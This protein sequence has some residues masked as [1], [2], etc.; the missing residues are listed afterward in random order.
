[1][2][3][4]KLFNFS[5]NT[6]ISLALLLILANIAF[7]VDTAKVKIIDT[8]GCNL[9]IVEETDTN[10][11]SLKS[12]SG[13][14]NW[15][16]GVFEGLDTSN[17]TTFSLC[18]DGTGTPE[19]PGDVSKWDGL[20]PVYTYGKYW[21]YN[22][23]I[24]YTKNADGYWVSSDIFA[25]EKLA[26]NGKT[27]EQTVIPTELSEEFLS[28]DGNYWSAWQE[29]QDT[30][31]NVGSNIF[32]LTKQFNSPNTSLAMRIPYTYDYEYE[33]MKKL[34]QANVSGVT[35]H[36]I[37]KSIRNHNLYVV[38]VSDSTASEEELKDRRVVLMYANEDGDEPDGC[39]VVN[40]AMN[41]LIQGIQNND[42][43]V[44]KILSEVTFLFIPLLD[45][46]G[47]SNS[48]YG[49]ITYDFKPASYNDVRSEVVLYAKF[50]TS[51]CGDANRR[52]DIVCNL[53]NVEC[54]EAP[55]V[56]CP[57]L[58]GNQ[59]EEIDNLNKFLLL[60]LKEL[61]DV[62]ISNIYWIIGGF[63]KNRFAGWCSNHWGNIQIS[64]EINSRYHHNRMSQYDINKLGES[65]AIS[66]NNYFYSVEYERAMLRINYIFSAQNKR[67]NDFI[68]EM[69][70]A[71]SFYQ[72]LGRGF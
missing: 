41:H 53:H 9:A 17:P 21:D 29:I 52:L 27:P 19:S 46:V 61:Q 37:G 43:E 59:I 14:H 4:E 16:A 50:I 38:E 1:M 26:G 18:M 67:R 5:V 2:G 69:G 32:T 24:Y 34:K 57:I 15:F 39:W 47:W 54:N 20:W 55:N 28:D 23:Y 36:E 3:V 30:K 45:P 7:G 10:T 68:A 71:Q 72:I 22:T 13:A 35:V 64:Y 25:K 33:Y 12:T 11:Y 42:K 44:K 51:W 31:I 63:S 6:A 48:T 66:F 65:F 49:E 70:K 62:H 56:L 8:A 40:G 58:E 60:R